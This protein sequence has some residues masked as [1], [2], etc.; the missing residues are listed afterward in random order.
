MMLRVLSSGAVSDVERVSILGALSSLIADAQTADV[1]AE[2][3]GSVVTALL[4]LGNDQC[5]GPRCGMVRVFVCMLKYIYNIIYIYLYVDV[6]V[7]Y[8][9]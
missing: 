5:V 1:V 7:S 2:H 3:L 4:A 9:S 6:R 8:H